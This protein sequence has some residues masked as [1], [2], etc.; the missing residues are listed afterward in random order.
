VDNWKAY[1]GAHSV[2]APDCLDFWD[3]DIDEDALTVGV[4]IMFDTTNFEDG[5]N[6]DIVWRRLLKHERHN[7]VLNR[8]LLTFFTVPSLFVV[9]RPDAGGLEIEGRFFTTAVKES[10]NIADVDRSPL[11]DDLWNMLLHSRSAT[12]LHGGDLELATRLATFDVLCASMRSW[13]DF[14]RYVSE[15]SAWRPEDFETYEQEPPLLGDREYVA[16][17]A[18]ASRDLIQAIVLAEEAVDL[19]ERFSNDSLRRWR[20]IKLQSKTSRETLEHVIK[21]T[22]D[23]IDGFVARGTALTQEAQADSL[24]RLTLV[25]SIF[26]PLTMACSLLSMS[27]RVNAIGA[28]WWDWLGIV[29]II[30]LLVVIGIRITAVFSDF[31]RSPKLQWY[32]RLIRQE[33]LKAKAKALSVQNSKPRHLRQRKLVPLTPRL[34][35]RSSRYLFLLGATISF[36]VGM[37]FQ[38]GNVAIG[39]EALGWSAAGVVGYVL[40]GIIVWRFMKGLWSLFWHSVQTSRTST[41]SGTRSRSRIRRRSQSSD[42][43][44]TEDASSNA[45]SRRPGTQPMSRSGRLIRKIVRLYL[46]G[47]LSGAVWT[48]KILHWIF[49]FF[50]GSLLLEVLK[51]MIL[52]LIRI[53]ASDS[54]IRAFEAVLLGRVAEYEMHRAEGDEEAQRAATDAQND[55]DAD[56][57]RIREKFEVKTS[58]GPV[59]LLSKKDVKRAQTWHGEPG[60]LERRSTQRSSGAGI[61]RAAARR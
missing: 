27:N 21:D 50:F 58:L 34:L 28:V 39:A 10:Y 30:G 22:E 26:L 40:V 35:F 56:E 49:N 37:F 43:P 60:G 41:R 4:N 12:A 2:A 23:Y 44:D 11:R 7:I 54:V 20:Q 52:K 29:L 9:Q 36:L 1:R 25:A 13:T 51:Y 5:E 61:T 31:R 24:K 18:R 42:S 19:I 46:V 55:G 33:F 16:D 32:R 45:S 15:K 17:F 59:N 53:N 47:G 57:S 6:D 14:C 3:R 38:G 48:L 8:A